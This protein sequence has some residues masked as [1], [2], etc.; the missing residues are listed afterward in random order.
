MVT[1]IVLLGPPASGKS[2][3]GAALGALGYRWREWEPVLIERWGSR[4]NFIANKERAL[5]EHQGDLA[6]FITEPGGTAVL[7][8]TGIS[9]APFLDILMRTADVFVVR[10]DVPLDAALGRVRGRTAGQHFSDDEDPNRAT[11]QAFQDLVVPNRTAN[12]V[13]DTTTVG[14]AEAAALIHEGFS[15]RSP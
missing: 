3:V 8:T 15:S 6:A 14:A 5:R 1:C 10:L 13:I 4:E 2:T 11:W 7:E 9:D 12:L